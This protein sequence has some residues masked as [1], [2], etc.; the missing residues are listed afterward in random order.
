MTPTAPDRYRAQGAPLLSGNHT[1]GA[2]QKLNLARPTQLNH[3]DSHSPGGRQRHSAVGKH[4]IKSSSDVNSKSSHR[5]LRIHHKRD[6][7]SREDTNS[8]ADSG[9]MSKAGGNGKKKSIRK[10]DQKSMKLAQ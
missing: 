6:H 8:V 1:P 2:D 5:K 7:S 10:S 9:F 3:A 4:E